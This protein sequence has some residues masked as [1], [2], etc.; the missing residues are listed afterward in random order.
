MPGLNDFLL[1]AQTDYA[2][3]LEFR[4]DP[5]GALAPYE[6]STEERAALTGSGAQLWEHLGRQTSHPE[7]LGPDPVVDKGVGLDPAIN[8]PI[9]TTQTSQAPARSDESAFDAAAVLS[10]PE[11]LETVARVRDARAHSERL[12]AVSALIEQIG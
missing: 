10:R 1:R 12:A 9:F 7:S 8:W 6:L 11:V 3:Y 2:F 5:H 4:K